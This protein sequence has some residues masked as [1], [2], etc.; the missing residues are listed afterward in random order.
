MASG[1]TL[2]GRCKDGTEFPADV[3][4]SP[5]TIDGE[6]YVICSVR[7]IIEAHAARRSCASR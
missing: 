2:F 5:V 4:L 6:L 7:N 3:A 1:L